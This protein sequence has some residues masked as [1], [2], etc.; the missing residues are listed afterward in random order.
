M[1]C[2]NTLIGKK[3]VNTN[4]HGGS[5]QKFPDHNHNL[6]HEFI[7]KG[8]ASDHTHLRLAITIDD[9][10]KRIFILG[11]ISRDETVFSEPP[12]PTDDRDK[13]HEVLHNTLGAG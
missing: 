13:F 10:G 5:L 4:R 8:R 9:I 3:L 11:P 12:S 1:N 6:A 7:D 2:K